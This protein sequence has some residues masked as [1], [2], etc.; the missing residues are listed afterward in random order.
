MNVNHSDRCPD[1]HRTRGVVESGKPKVPRFCWVRNGSVCMRTQLAYERAL[2]SPL[3][4]V[5][6]Q[7]R[8]VIA[9]PFFESMPLPMRAAVLELARSVVELDA[10]EPPI[11]DESAAE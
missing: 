7:A 11:L 6:E 1:C 5:L 8:S 2:V 3:R 4:H 10:V 9:Q